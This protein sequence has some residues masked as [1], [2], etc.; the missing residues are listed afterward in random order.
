MEKVKE[1]IP[2]MVSNAIDTGTNETEILH[3]VG[4]HNRF[5]NQRGNSSSRR[6]SSF[7]P[8]YIRRINRL[9]PNDRPSKCAVCGSI[10]HWAA[11]CPDKDMRP[12]VDDEV[13]ITLIAQNE[14]NG[15]ED[16]F[17]MAI[18]D[19]G[20]TKTVCGDKWSSCYIDGLEDSV[21]SQIEKMPLSTGFRFGEGKRVTSMK[22]LKLPCKISS[23]NAYITT[24]VVPVDIP[25]LLSKSSMERA[26]TI[27]EFAKE[28]VT[29]LGEELETV[30]NEAGHCCIYLGPKVEEVFLTTGETDD[31]KKSHETAQ[32]VCPC[33]LT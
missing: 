20:C 22:S 2:V 3:A 9:G 31:L 19:S 32:T 6:G 28:K 1:E 13:H 11:K 26:N 30:K 16:T 33:K 25:L 12:K 5:R 18:L 10:F 17:G 21:S 29:M 7:T 8:K 27:I 14:P 23:K 4:G 24:E 15:M